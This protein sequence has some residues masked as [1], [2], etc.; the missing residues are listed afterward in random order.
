M[1][2]IFLGLN[3]IFQTSQRIWSHLAAHATRLVLTNSQKK[4]Q[5]KNNNNGDSWIK[6]KIKTKWDNC[7]ETANP[8]TVVRYA[9][10]WISFHSGLFTGIQQ[11][12]NRQWL[13]YWSWTRRHQTYRNNI[14][15]NNRVIEWQC[16]NHL[17]ADFFIF[18]V[19]LRWYKDISYSSIQN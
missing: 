12:T 11:T 9:F 19:I 2:S 3:A 10:W 17:R 4:Q 7:I 14:A 6:Q 15:P 18:I 13:H 1:A 16:I 5:Q 8:L